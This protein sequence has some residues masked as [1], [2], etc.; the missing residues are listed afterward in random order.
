MRRTIGWSAAAAL[1][2][3]FPAAPA[4]AEFF[5]FEEMRG[6]CRGE[7]DQPADFRTDAGY[8]LLAASLRERC[9]MYLLGLAETNLREIGT[10][11]SRQGCM[12]DQA[13]PAEVAEALAE[14]LAARAEPPEEG[15]AGLV[16]EVL[17]ARYGC[18]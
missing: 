3:A 5:S 17:R 11:A 6:M 7:T 2:A 18:G 14:A 4:A 9:R 8:R 15:L 10:V 1:L 12:A 13:P 16:R